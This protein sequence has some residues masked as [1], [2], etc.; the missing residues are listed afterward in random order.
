MYI[1]LKSQWFLCFPLTLQISDEFDYLKSD[2]AMHCL[3][4]GVSYGPQGMPLIEQLFLLICVSRVTKKCHP[5][6]A[7]S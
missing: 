7:G 5:D 6:F 4:G 2:L 1:Y 3:Y